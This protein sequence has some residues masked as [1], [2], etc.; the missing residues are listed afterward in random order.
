MSGTTLTLYLCLGDWELANFEQRYISNLH[1]TYI[2]ARGCTWIV[3]DCVATTQW[4]ILQ[5]LNYQM[6]STSKGL[7]VTGE[8]LPFMILLGFVENVLKVLFAKK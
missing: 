7:K 2:V 3:V 1:I 5:Y 4:N 8:P 6:S